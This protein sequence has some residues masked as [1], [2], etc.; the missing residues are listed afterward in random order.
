MGATG[1]AGTTFAP[2]GR[3]YEGA[4]CFSGTRLRRP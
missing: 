3:S 2:M 4:D 1:F